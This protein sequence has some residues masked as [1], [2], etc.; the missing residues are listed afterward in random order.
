MPNPA[1]TGP[2]RIQRVVTLVIL[3]AG[4]AATGT[5]ARDVATTAESAALADVAA[6]GEE[7]VRTT[8]GIE[9]AAIAKVLAV[10]GFIESSLPVDDHALGRFVSIIDP[11]GSTSLAYAPLE[12]TGAWTIAYTNGSG[13]VGFA[14]GE[15]LGAIAPISNTIQ[16]A[17]TYGTPQ[18]STF[19][20]LPG[21]DDSDDLVIVS[22]AASDGNPV[23]AV[24]ATMRLDESLDALVARR[25]GP[26]YQ[27]SRIDPTTATDSSAVWAQRIDNVGRPLV[28]SIRSVGDRRDSAPTA[29][30]IILGATASASAA[31]L[32][33]TVTG[34]RAIAR[35]LARLE[36]TL[37]DKDR[38]LATVSHELRTPL[39]SVVGFLEILG[40]EEIDL[41]DGERVSFLRN[42]REGATDIER[43]VEDHLTAARLSAGALTIKRRS[44]DLQREVG[45]AAAEFHLPQHLALAMNLSGAGFGDDLRIRQI[46]RN[47]LRN[48]ARYAHSR[49]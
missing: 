44:V 29:W 26:A 9:G 10:R 35:R 12:W 16:R 40:T 28:L 19:V 5:F 36:A 1:T 38:F 14:V 13:R 18:A 46:V 7:L 32:G 45:R 8:Q 2:S 42:A 49:I 17:W 25:P 43:I 30:I 23:G 11:D 33:W 15:D 4:I 34:R 6:T 3:L 41:T 47:I 20:E 24:A 39:T 31:Y 27:L 21:D 48:A 22:V 37:A